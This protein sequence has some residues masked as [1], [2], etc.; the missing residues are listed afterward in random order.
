VFYDDLYVPEFPDRDERESLENI[1]E[2]LRRKSAGW[3]GRN[4]YHVVLAVDGPRILGG[5]IFD[6]LA[7]ADAGVLEFLVVARAARRHGL[8]R[9][10]LGEA[11]RLLAA[12]GRATIGRPPRWVLAEMNDPFW[13]ER[14]IDTLDPFDR[15]AIWGRW[16]FHRLRFPYV[17]PALDP[18][19]SPV[20][21]LMLSV[22]FLTSGTHDTMPSGAVITALR[23]YVRW[24]MRID[25]PEASAEYRAMAAHLE[26][27]SVVDTI[28]LAAYVGRDPARPLEIREI[29]PDDDKNLQ[30]VMAVYAAA[31]KPGPTTIEPDRFRVSL[32]RPRAADEHYHLWALARA[33]GDPVEGMTSFFTFPEGGF[34]GYLALTGSLRGTGRSHLVLSRIE[35]RMIRDRVGASGW[36]IE[37][38][39]ESGQAT[40]FAAA[41][42]REVAIRYRQPPLRGK[43]EGPVLAL[44]YKEFGARGTTPVLAAATL[45]EALR[46]F[47]SR[48][49]GLDP[50]GTDAWVHAVASDA[51]PGGVVWRTDD[52]RQ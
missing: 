10:L 21:H 44:M 27:M 6:F 14:V 33:P 37:C 46:K 16:G 5:V 7:D 3:Y 32:R 11:E 13:P 50:A 28:P 12:D 4:N 31:F 25:V 48:V 23:E 43:S 15:A 18:D 29:A 51:S 38:E 34:G 26:A 41:G 2:Y 30:A 49:Y 9:A 17:Q 24:A 39:P 45:C 8:G 47:G 22:K 36:F 20:H 40:I 1:Q 19:K 52:R 35:E 42:F